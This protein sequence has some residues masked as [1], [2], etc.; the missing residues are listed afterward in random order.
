MGDVIP[1]SPER[2][3][4]TGSLHPP[5]SMDDTEISMLK[6]LLTDSLIP[7]IEAAPLDELPVGCW[8]IMDADPGYFTDAYELLT[9]L[10]ET[11]MLRHLMCP[12]EVAQVLTHDS[13]LLRPLDT[14]RRTAAI[15]GFKLRQVDQALAEGNDPD[16]ALEIVDGLVENLVEIDPD[17]TWAMFHRLADELYPMPTSPGSAQQSS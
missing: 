17:A 4:E 14:L 5:V 11:I 2:R 3:P 7:V 8:R 12:E 13:Q 6:A 9:T 15:T 1:I 10:E 16:R